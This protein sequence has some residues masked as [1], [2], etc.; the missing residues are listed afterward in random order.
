MYLIINPRYDYI[1]QNNNIIPEYWNSSFYNGE[2]LVMEL[3]IIIN[4]ERVS[5]SQKHI[6]QIYI[7][8]IKKEKPLLKIEYCSILCDQCNNWI[9]RNEFHGNCD[10]CYIYICNDCSNYNYDKVYCENCY[11]YIIDNDSIS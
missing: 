5:V 10:K 8:E 7:E 3:P 9:D 1:I 4:F 11:D 6:P 2:L